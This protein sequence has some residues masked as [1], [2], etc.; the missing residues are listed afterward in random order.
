MTLTGELALRVHLSVTYH[1]EV[2]PGVENPPGSPGMKP[3][4]RI[5]SKTLKKEHYGK[6]PEAL[7]RRETTSLCL[8]DSMHADLSEEE[9][10]LGLTKQ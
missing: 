7:R 5:I 2:L 10:A 3:H 8:S 1:H 6:L 4:S 9:Q